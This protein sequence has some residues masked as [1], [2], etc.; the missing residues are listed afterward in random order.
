MKKTIILFCFTFF[1]SFSQEKSSGYF[2]VQ[3]FRGN[4]IKHSED[5]G[6]LI[7]GH[8]DGFMLSYNWKTFG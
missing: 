3:L 5:V 6:H 7:S 8:P 2:D 4:I 1:L